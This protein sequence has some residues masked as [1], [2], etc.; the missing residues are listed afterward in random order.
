MQRCYVAAAAASSIVGED[1]FE[2]GIVGE[3]N[4]DGGNIDEE[5][6]YEET[7]FLDGN[8]FIQETKKSVD[9]VVMSKVAKS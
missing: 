3:E 9:S 5:V 6:G 8:S 1:N 7:D 4:F 2:K